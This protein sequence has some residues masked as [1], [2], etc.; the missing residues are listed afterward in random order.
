[1]KHTNFK[2]KAR[3]LFTCI[4]FLTIAVVANAQKT[5]VKG[6]VKDAQTG[7]P[8]LGANIFEKGTTNGTITNFDGEFTLEAATN[9]TLVVK[10]VG[11]Q[12]TEIP[13]A[14]KQNLVI[15]L[16]EDAIAISEVMVIGYGTVKKSDATGSVTAIKPDKLN[17]GLTTNAQDM[18]MGK[19][20]GVNITTGGGTPGGSAT[21]RIR[22][23]SSLNASNDPLIVIDG[24]A[25]D[26]EGIKGVAN[27]LSAINPN[28]I[29]TFTVLKDA[30]ATAI[31]GSR[32]SNG[33][34]IITTK[35]GEKGSKPRVS[36]EGNMS[37]SN[38]NETLSVMTGDEFRSYVQT[39]YADKPEIV[40]KLGT[41]NTN[42]QSQIYQ[43]AISQD[44]NIS[45]L[46]GFKNVPYRFS[47]GYTNQNGI[48]KTSNFERFTGAF[49]LSPSLFNDYLK[50]NI[51]AKGM[52]VNNRFADGGVVGSAAAMDPTQ[53]ITSTDD[54]F[55]K[56]FG[57]YYQ[58]YL[59]DSQTGV[60]A[61]NSNAV[62][63]PLAT[64][65]QKRDVSNAKDFIGS[66]D[67]DYKVHFLPEL[68]MHLNL[69]M[70]A[71]TGTQTLYVDSLSA[72]D[73]HH[74]R[75]GWESISKIN[76]SLSYYMQ[77]AKEI[78][79]NKFD[80][81]G[82]YEW[83]KFH[84]EKDNAY[85]GLETDVVD[86]ETGY[87]GG[88][89]YK[90]YSSKNENFLVS[91]FGRA[92]YSFG[93]KY[94]ATFTL[95][96]DGSSFFSAK[97]RWGL[98][99]SAAFAWKIN[100]ENFLKNNKYIS[101]FKLRL[102]YGVTG[103]QNINQG[104]APYLPIY[105]V[106]KTG[107]SYPLGDNGEYL[108]TYKPVVY[109]SNLKWEQ[110]S[111][112]N[113]GIDFGVLNS[114][115]TASLDYYHRITTDLLNTVEIPAGSNFSNQVISNI[116][117]LKNDGIEFSVNAKAISTKDLIWEIGYNVTHNRNE[118]IKLTTGSKENY[119]VETGGIS[120]GTGNNI[121]AHAVGYTASSFYVFEQVYDEATG[122]P[123]PGEFVNRYIDYEMN[124]DGTF[125]TDVNG[126]KIPLETQVINEKDKYF[127]HNPSPDV[128]MGLSSKLIY[129][130]FDFGISLR[131]SIGNYVYND[132]A[133]SHANISV[134]NVYSAD[135]FTNIQSSAMETNFTGNNMGDYFKSDY[136]V[137]NASFIRCDNIT[138]GYTLKN[139]FKVISTGRV[140][141]TVQNPF[142][143]SSYKGLDPEIYGGIDN[144]IYPRPM[145]TM[146]GLSLNF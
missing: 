135:A 33:V 128:T 104:D 9:A 5:T 60:T 73:T 90:P 59:T 123:I 132:V 44:H 34:I 57:G 113:G 30:S 66:A 52:I 47:A 84:R 139:L 95:R 31:Y 64:L 98:F 56:N 42:W 118:I 91:F 106:S 61:G 86:A 108:T 145:I 120:S 41:S 80:V 83:Q 109:N 102:G 134:S 46:G 103:Q 18:I 131:A 12:P 8:I 68:R 27:P 4:A 138:L 116:G 2:Q 24:L 28:D 15:Q 136:Y 75:Q 54:I 94:L 6:V 63:N 78:G 105:S 110:T 16:K 117:S 58:W 146:V 43:T 111:T 22:G 11:Y 51:N 45:V 50:I 124:L 143:V 1:M 112:Y 122:K 88:Y 20:A 29:E 36:Y 79:R 72:S 130:N 55:V 81:M 126:D 100:E 96:N 53:A 32:A 40:S 87:I 14:G 13:V 69:G 76:Q 115:I 85:E 23:G 77:Y 99:P 21:I 35:K 82:G 101:D 25:M 62:K 49:N 114:R 125:K 67:F 121:Q 119:I 127:Y 71:S 10:Y 26:N 144:N 141:A 70:E 93:N 48:I 39:L 107:A 19:I 17:K 133:A 137:Q 3:T 92:N 129:K 97:N 65:N 140:Y 89:D 7:D 74:G 37:V 38:I 142:V